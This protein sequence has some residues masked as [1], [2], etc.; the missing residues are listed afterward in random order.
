MIEDPFNDFDFDGDITTVDGHTSIID[1]EGIDIDGIDVDDASCLVP[2]CILTCDDLAQF[3]A[4]LDREM[5]WSVQE[6][7]KNSSHDSISN[8]ARMIPVSSFKDAD[9]SA[10]SLAES[11]GIPTNYFGTSSEQL[12]KHTAT[13]KD[14]ARK[15]ALMKAG[16][17]V[18]PDFNSTMEAKWEELLSLQQPT[19]RVSEWYARVVPT[20]RRML[21]SGK[22]KGL[23]YDSKVLLEVDFARVEKWVKRKRGQLLEPVKTG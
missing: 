19:E 2:P 17:F 7:S 8:F 3:G 18:S 21:L 5:E 14:V 16:Y 20:Y 22:T 15:R 12:Q 13:N 1:E 11:V 9:A 6:S 10:K 23:E 4:R